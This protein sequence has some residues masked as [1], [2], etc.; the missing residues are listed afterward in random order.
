MITGIDYVFYTE[1]NAY[2][3][4]YDFEKRIINIWNHFYKEHDCEDGLINVF[5]SKNKKMLQSIEEKGYNLNE[6]GEGA[7]LIIFNEEKLN[8]KNSITLITPRRHEDSLF[9]RNIVDI[10]NDI[11]SYRDP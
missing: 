4:F 6:D 11:S 9:C 3:F 7:F 5:Y 1:K 2:F 10:V 8:N